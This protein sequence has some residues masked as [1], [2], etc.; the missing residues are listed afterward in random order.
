MVL[1]FW[2]I[3]SRLPFLVVGLAITNHSF[4]LVLFD[5]PCNQTLVIWAIG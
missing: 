5:Y 3:I 2:G 4:A 1:K